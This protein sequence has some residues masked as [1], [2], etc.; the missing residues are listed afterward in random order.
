MKPITTVPTTTLPPGCIGGNESTRICKLEDKNQQLTMN[1][2]GFIQE[3]GVLKNQNRALN[4]TVN[5][6]QDQ[7]TVLTNR[8]CSCA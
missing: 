3:I 4:D 8:P 2:K 5:Q 1:F 7:V 6:L